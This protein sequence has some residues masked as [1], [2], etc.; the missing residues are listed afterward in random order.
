MR[1]RGGQGGVA[2]QA[3]DATLSGMGPVEVSVT[4]R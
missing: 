1:R 3:D 2:S 4:L